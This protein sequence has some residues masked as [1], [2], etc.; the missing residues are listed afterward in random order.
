MLIGGNAIGGDEMKYIMLKDCSSGEPVE[1]LAFKDDD[2]K[3]FNIQADIDEANEYYY[4]G[5][6]DEIDEKYNCQE[7]Y[8]LHCLWEKY[9][10]D[11]I[12][13]SNDDGLYF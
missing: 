2:V 4:D 3:L 6:E 7:E 11:V 12:P 5:H 8:V 9:D 13:W 1:L 10:F